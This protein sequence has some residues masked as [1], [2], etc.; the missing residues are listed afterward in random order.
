VAIGPVADERYRT[1]WAQARALTLDTFGET[2]LINAI[3][4][5]DY[6][7]CGVP[8]Y[9]RQLRHM[10]A[11][12]TE[13][14]IRALTVPVLVVRGGADP[15]AGRSW[16]RRLRDAA[17]VS[18]LIEIPHRFHVAQHSAP[19]AVADAI[20]FHTESRWPDATEMAAAS[21]SEEA[22]SIR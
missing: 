9:L 1:V 2:P 6:V 17:R 22:P 12:P 18:R 13:R 20:R 16:S 4:L 7:R 15:V 5:T 10:L 11:Y 21:H 8:W 14:R 3:V 19:S